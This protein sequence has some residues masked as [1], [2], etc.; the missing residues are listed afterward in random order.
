MGFIT[1]SL[2]F[3]QIESGCI[4]T[5]SEIQGH[6]LTKSVESVICSNKNLE[7]EGSMGIKNNF[8]IFVILA[9]CLMALS[10]SGADLEKTITYVRLYPDETGE[11]HFEDVK[12]KLRAEEVQSPEVPF[13]ITPFEKATSYGY[14]NPSAGY[15]E[16]WH[17]APQRQFLFC[18]SGEYEIK[19]SDGEVR[20]FGQGSILLVEDTTGKGHV[21][22]CPGSEGALALVVTLD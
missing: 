19:A 22:S 16:D 2:F 6:F 14:Y 17:N 8:M 3:I 10:Y 9:A 11:S 20:R 15:F 12:I 5:L 21:S 1:L 7:P 4:P 18:L 13:Y